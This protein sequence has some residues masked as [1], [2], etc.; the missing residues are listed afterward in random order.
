MGLERNVAKFPLSLRVHTTIKFG[1]GAIHCLKFFLASGQG[2]NTYYKNSGKIL[3]EAL[4]RPWPTPILKTYKVATAT[5]KVRDID[6][7]DLLSMV[8]ERLFERFAL[9][10]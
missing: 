4:S 8:M 5:S 3:V 9:M 2:S 7:L 6:Y 10:P 1:N